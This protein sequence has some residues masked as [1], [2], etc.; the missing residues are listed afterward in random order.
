MHYFLFES[1]SISKT[2]RLK[3]TIIRGVDDRVSS[4][5]TVSKMLFQN[6]ADEL[7]LVS[8]LMNS[9]APL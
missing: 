2:L 5:E 9:F 3:G 1:E 7:L 8:D 4:I 6:I